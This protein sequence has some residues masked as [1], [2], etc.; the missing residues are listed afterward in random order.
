M[1]GGLAGTFLPAK[2]DTAPRGSKAWHHGQGVGGCAGGLPSADL[3]RGAVGAGREV[4]K[5]GDD[6]VGSGTAPRPA[7]CRRRG[8][9][10]CGR[11]SFAAAAVDEA[12]VRR[13]SAGGSWPTRCWTAAGGFPASTARWAKP[14]GVGSAGSRGAAISRSQASAASVPRRARKA[15]TVAAQPRKRSGSRPRTAVRAHPP[16]SP[17]RPRVRRVCPAAA[18]PGSRAAG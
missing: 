15:G 5:V 7:G 9:S 3:G 6:A 11:C 10:P 14:S 13:E 12:N 4:D 18:P 1:P 16:R 17:P 8:S 2:A